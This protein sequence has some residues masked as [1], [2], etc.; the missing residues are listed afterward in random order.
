ML[1]SG[2]TT[3]MTEST[4]QRLLATSPSGAFGYEVASAVLGKTGLNSK[5]ARMVA[6]GELIRIKRGFF[7]WAPA[8]RKTALQVFPIANLLYGPSYIS[9]ESAL[10]YYGLIP[11]HSF[12]V[13]SVTL[14]RVKSFETPIGRFVYR[15]VKPAAFPV[16]V[17]SVVI[18]ASP[19]ETRRVLLASP[20]KALLDKLYLD[21]PSTAFL[22]YCR[23]SLRIEERALKQLDLSSLR[24]IS[25]SYKSTRFKGR[26]KEFCRQLADG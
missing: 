21:A 4:I 9:L 8:L 7:V 19:I 17:K 13:T 12:S 1:V 23:E 22:D 24:D 16:G 3:S 20:E 5:L 26:I 25:L 6:A 14:H 11:E 15:V 2:Y 10:A 18:G